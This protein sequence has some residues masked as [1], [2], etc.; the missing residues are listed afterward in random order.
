MPMHQRCALAPS[1]SGSSSAGSASATTLPVWILRARI[2][3]GERWMRATC[4]DSKSSADSSYSRSLSRCDWE[5]VRRE[6]EE[7]DGVEE[8]VEAADQG[9]SVMSSDAAELPDLDEEGM[10]ARFRGSGAA[11]ASIVKGREGMK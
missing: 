3:C 6:L 5:T 9:R 11:L 1:V 2:S 10:P 8:E 7:E 4:A